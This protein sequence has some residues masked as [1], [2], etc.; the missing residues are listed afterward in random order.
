[1]LEYHTVFGAFSVLVSLIAYALY[2]R[3]VL[4]G[5]TR[6]HPFTWLIFAVIDGIVFFAQ[7][8]NGA[9]PGAWVLGFAT[10][11]NGG[12]FLLS[13][14]SG[15]KRIARIDWICLG[16]AM[17]GII[18]WQMTNQALAAVVFASISDALAKVPTIRKS[19]LRPYQESASV[20]L[21]DVFKFAFS[22]VALTAITPT[23]VLFPAAAAC[24]NA[25]VVIVVLLRRWQLARIA[26]PL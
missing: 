5:V 7:V 8:L 13:L 17:L 15:E 22:I 1:M 20:W 16:F 9:G 24:T 18:L 11:A 19:I 2:Y 10:V 3:S 25:I 14:R 26:P 23:T 4:K 6:P 12:I 21:I